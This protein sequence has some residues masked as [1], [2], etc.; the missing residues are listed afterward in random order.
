M[1]KSIRIGG[2][3]GFWGDSYRATEQLIQDATL[4]FIVYDYLAEITMSIMARARAKSPSAGYATDF[5][6]AVIKPYIRRISTHNTRLISNAGGVNPEKCAEVISELVKDLQLNLK[7]SCITG[8]DLMSSVQD[9]K[10]MNCKEMFSDIKFPEIDK[11]ASM[12]AYLG[13][14]AISKALD[15]GADIVI[16]GRCVDSAVTLGACI[17]AFNWTKSDLDQLAG[18]SLAGHILECGAQATGGNFT[19]WELS[20]DIHNIGY[21]IAEISND[22]IFEISK[23]PNT[24]GLVNVGTVSE[25]MLYEIGDPKKY[26]LP[27]VI[28]DFSEVS[29]TEISQN[30]VRLSG[31]KGLHPSNNYK[32]CATYADGYRGGTIMT[33]Y[34]EDSVKKADYL[35]ESIFKASRNTLQKLGL[36][37][38]T[39][40][41]IE[42]IGAESQYGEFARNQS[43]REVAIKIAAKHR[44]A[45]GIGI[46]L[47][48]CVGL[49]LAT[50]PGLSGFQGGRARPSPVIR[51]FSFEIPKSFVNIYIDGQIF[52]DSQEKRSQKL[53]KQK[54]L[55]DAPPKIKD[56]LL[57]PLKLKKLAY[58]R[59]GDKGN[60]ANIGIICRQPEYL[61][62]V[63]YS[64]TE[65]A[66]MERLSHFISG[67]SLEE[68]LKHV[69]RFLLPG[70]SAINFLITDVL[71]GGG[72]ASIRN[73]AQGKGFAQLLLDSPIMVSQWIADEIDG[74]EDIA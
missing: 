60:S 68:K 70:I 53:N 15:K 41:S 24:G 54:V 42:L 32:V 35:S 5:I 6:D 8:D 48:E 9:L 61:S 22:G 23:L 40:T 45:A 43:V 21:P 13:A 31:A 59:S 66:V 62:Y 34:G 18:G 27:D 30:K 28:C 38:F 33:M 7:V 29:I 49:G 14:F 71:G 72:I 56:K 37:D 67:D 4:D 52:E 57:V 20:K 50:P 16:T 73:D 58:A 39:E 65:R 2:A 19:D 51:L 25:Q 74:N 1:N 55:P 12:N 63:Y 11:V 69:T 47:K 10:N 46:F 3:S 36:E 26:M 64:L 17:H 44:D